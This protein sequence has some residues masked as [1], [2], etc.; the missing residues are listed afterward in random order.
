MMN[1]IYF[2]TVL[3]VIS[4]LAFSLPGAYALRLAQQ[5]KQN[6]RAAYAAAEAI[7]ED[8]T[9][10]IERMG[11]RIEALEQENGRLLARLDLAETEIER[12]ERENARLGSAVRRLVTQVGALGKEPDVD[13]AVLQ[14]LARE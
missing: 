7:Q 5:S 1:E 12:L 3:I 13:P 11:R 6:G 9:R 8:V 4:G 2:L 14:R 10:Q